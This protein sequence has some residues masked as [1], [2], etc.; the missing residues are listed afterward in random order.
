MKLNSLNFFIKFFERASALPGG[1]VQL[2]AQVKHLVEVL[3][4]FR[5][6]SRQWTADN[7]RHA[8]KEALGIEKTCL[9][10]ARK[11]AEILKLM[12]AES[13]HFS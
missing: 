6:E 7:K 2:F 3:K 12:L 8:I 9:T 1:R 13:K 10:N 4:N 5:A 11:C